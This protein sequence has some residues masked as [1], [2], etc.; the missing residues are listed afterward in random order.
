MKVALSGMILG[1]S[2]L[3]ANAASLDTTAYTFSD[4]TTLSFDGDTLSKTGTGVIEC[5][6]GYVIQSDMANQGSAYRDYT[7]GDI[8]VGAPTAT[9]REA[10]EDGEVLTYYCGVP[11]GSGGY[12]A[13]GSASNPA[14]HKNN[15]RIRVD[16]QGTCSQ[17]AEFVAADTAV[18]DSYSSSAPITSEYVADSITAKI[19]FKCKQPE[20]FAPT[21]DASLKFVQKTSGDD[22]EAIS[23]IVRVVVGGIPRD[24]VASDVTKS[25]LALTRVDGK[26]FTLSTTQ[27]YSLGTARAHPD[28]Y[29]SGG[30]N[31]NND[32]CKG[33]LRLKLNT[34][35]ASRSDADLTFDRPTSLV[36]AANFDP[37]RP[38]FRQ[39]KQ[40][41]LT[42]EK[43]YLLYDACY[44]SGYAATTQ[45]GG[46]LL[47][48]LVCPFNGVKSDSTQAS[49][50]DCINDGKVESEAFDNTCAGIELNILPTVM[51]SAN[52]ADVHTQELTSLM[53]KVNPGDPDQ[54]YSFK[55]QFEESKTG[56]D[57]RFQDIAGLNA[58]DI[59]GDATTTLSA[60]ET[61]FQYTFTLTQA[62]VDTL[63]A[64][65]SD[66]F[67]KADV[68]GASWMKKVDLA[69][70]ITVSGIPSIATN[71]RLFG[72]VYQTCSKAETEL[73]A[74]LALGRDTHLKET[75]RFE[76]V[77]L[78]S[79]RF[80]Y[81]RSAQDQNVDLTVDENVFG[82]EGAGKVRIC[83]PT[84]DSTDAHCQEEGGSSLTL[85]ADD[86]ADVFA[87]ITGTCDNIKDGVF[88]GLVEFE[89]AHRA[90]A[91]VLCKGTCTN[92]V[93]HDL[94]LDWS[95]NFTVSS[96][97]GASHNKLVA[98]QAASSWSDPARKTNGDK[99]FTAKKFAYLIDPLITDECGADGVTK[100]GDVA[101]EA[102]SSDASSGG[103]L[104][105]KEIA[106]PDG[107]VSS[108][109]DSGLNTAT[110]V[111]NWLAACGTATDGG[112]KAKLVQR[113]SVDYD[114]NYV[115][116]NTSMTD[117]SFCHVRDLE[118]TVQTLVVDSVTAD[119]T[120]AQM[121][122]PGSATRM[123]TNIGNV[124]YEQCPGG[125]YKVKAYIDIDAD[126]LSAATWTEDTTTSATFFDTFDASGKTV[127]WVTGCENV[128]DEGAEGILAI[129]N[130][131]A[132]HTL[133]GKI[134]RASTSASQ[135]N[136]EVSFSF[137]VKLQGDPC[138]KE[139][140]ISAGDVELTL[141]KVDPLVAGSHTCS[142]SD[143]MSTASPQADGGFCGRLE[144]SNM[145]NFE[146]TILD[147]MVTRET[148]G[149][150]PIFLCEKAGDVTNG[151]ACV[152]D[153][154]GQLFL[155][156][157][158]DTSNLNTD[159]AGVNGAKTLASNNVFQLKNVDAFGTIKYTIFWKQQLNTGGRRLLRSTHVFGAGDHSSVASLVVLP[160]SAQI[161]DAA[162]SLDAKSEESQD[163]GD[164]AD[165]EE[166]SGLS[167]GAIAGIIAGGVVVAGGIAYYAVQA[168]QGGARIRKPE[169]AGYSAVRR[170]E[171]F[172][173][174]NF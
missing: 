8:S 1:A 22:A 138:N 39:C 128:C 110:D 135:G 126:D 149:S 90:A 7:S 144:L 61:K 12:L 20:G 76:Q 94:Q 114:S 171:R 111:Q 52:K 93:M 47:E 164:D 143:S 29:D 34:Q 173:T 10:H 92:A 9:L 136:D 24:L 87:H 40:D 115:D 100:T 37:H 44:P 116:Q 96:Q 153:P 11:D 71:I 30:C 165:A 33:A 148:P 159:V 43:S 109:S 118:V 145:G 170:S 62:S 65:A 55:Y 103:C 97:A 105:H 74:V 83:L 59:S 158:D 156:G 42:E 66:F 166:D 5:T 18:S 53:P 60:D 117:E 27:T 64:K 28:Y 169:A 107:S 152:G 125:A 129:W 85:R 82:T 19:D 54:P 4:G 124:Q 121:S 31:S 14:L 17:A 160:A 167:G 155:F 108:E 69:T 127:T 147:T 99:Y 68:Q 130:R 106:A 67:V 102:L 72:Q 25:G 56:A 88:G 104:V 174:M 112:S 122:D 86:G 6:P 134:S 45:V 51:T 3:G 113:F 38:Q 161:E 79:D 168:T 75:G 163:A 48:D 78:C 58:T 101:L 137:N 26:E 172:S 131:A 16:L 91:P 23:S 146:F 133:A 36:D 57:Q 63:T 84:Y 141:Y 80:K 123:S 139:S 157:A 151:E 77:A 50:Q 154:R 95:V 46:T 41:A 98:D 21:M 70:S 15:N 140:S 89:E 2:M 49:V 81:V 132:G 73:S 32:Q 142:I 13:S 119:L 120:V 35:A 150:E 162:E